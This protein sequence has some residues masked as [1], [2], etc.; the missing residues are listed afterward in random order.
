MISCVRAGFGL[1]SLLLVV[2]TISI[3]AGPSRHAMAERVFALITKNVGDPNFI[4][5]WRGCNDAARIK[6]DR[7]VHLGGDNLG[8]FRAQNRAIEDA[9]GEGYSGV[10]IS[11]TK[12]EFIAENGLPK[13]IETGVPVI[14]FDSDLI[15][16]FHHLRQAFI[17]VENHLIGR[18]LAR[19]LQNRLPFGG[20]VCLMSAGPYDPN[21]NERINGFRSEIRKTSDLGSQPPLNGS[22]G[23]FESPRCP[24]FN[25]DNLDLAM[26]QFRQSMLDDRLD[27]FITVGS[28]PLHDPQRY[29]QTF[30]NLPADARQNRP[31]IL[32]GGTGAPT[33]EHVSILRDKMV[34]GLVAID[35]YNLGNVVYHYLVSLTQDKVLGDL[36]IVQP[37]FI[38]EDAYSNKDDT[39]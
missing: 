21:L 8:Y 7:C 1:Q 14:T 34:D 15:A 36:P 9:V 26:T 19:E 39:Q 20:N 30:R 16:P 25:K 12:S 2:A 10:A 32:I 4:E 3:F 18:M 17:G 28:W 35:F 13:L 11:V 33:R 5:A 27:A 31:L 23:W 24:W 37:H 6:G 22:G 29:V 38:G